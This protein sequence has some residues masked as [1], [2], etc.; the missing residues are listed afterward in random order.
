MESVP[1]FD[2]CYDETSGVDDINVF[3]TALRGLD[4]DLHYAKATTDK[5]SPRLD[6]EG[7]CGETPSITSPLINAAERLSCYANAG[8]GAADTRGVQ[9]KTEEDE[10][11]DNLNSKN[12]ILLSKQIKTPT[13]GLGFSN[14]SGITFKAMNQTPAEFKE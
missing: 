11:C 3:S 1:N 2:E 5:M 7:A 4:Y 14:L 13:I 10:F 9:L 6:I 8:E 12:G